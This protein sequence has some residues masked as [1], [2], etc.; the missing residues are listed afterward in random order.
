[1]GRRKS[2]SQE[3]PMDDIGPEHGSDLLMKPINPDNWP[4]ESAPDL[5]KILRSTDAFGTLPIETQ[6]RIL[7]E[8][9]KTISASSENSH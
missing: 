2:K 1:M 7:A 6:S 3:K 5:I 8:L 4:Q 9:E